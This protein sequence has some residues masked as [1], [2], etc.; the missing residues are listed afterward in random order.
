[1]KKR[2]KKQKDKIVEYVT[3]I[4]GMCVYRLLAI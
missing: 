3:L 1:M 4:N 2:K